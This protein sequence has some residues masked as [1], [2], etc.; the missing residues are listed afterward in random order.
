MPI[1]KP[2]KIIIVGG[3]IGGLSSALALAKIGCDVS[4]LERAKE[5]G[6]IGAG[7]Q[8]GPNGFH[9]LDKLGVG[10]K[11]KET[12]VHVDA[13]NLMDSTDGKIITSIN[14]DSD[15]INHFGNPYRVIHR[16]D[17]LDEL[18]L[19]CK[20]HPK[21]TLLNNCRVASYSNTKKSVIIRTVSGEEFI[22]DA[23]IG[24]DG[25][26]SQIRAQMTG[27]DPLRVP[28][29]VTYRAVVSKFD[30]PAFAQS[31]S[32][33]LW[34]GPK[35]HVVHYPLKG[36]T[37]INLV[38]TFQGEIKDIGETGSIGEKHELMMHFNDSVDSLKQLLNAPVSWKKWIL[39]D[40]EPISAWTDGRVTLLGDAA[41][42]TLQYMAQGA[43]MAL[44]DSVCIASMLENS[45]GDVRAAFARYEVE[46]MPRSYRVVLQ[47]RILGDIYHA[48]GPYR[49]VRNT[50]FSGKSNNDHL[51]SLKWL[52]NFKVA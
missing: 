42:P 15:F 38:A 26:N 45:E 17:L 11:I 1:L 46:R 52:Y 41:H 12:S 18:L 19:A 36:N 49:M 29:H 16:A 32:V 7:I 22:G 40:R 5:F 30:V 4:V 21:I 39:A 51:H 25:L 23:A 2:L 14:L 3:G 13:L 47:S 31:N 20:N 50:M 28:G 9:A 35:C 10:K 34:A 48:Q 27:G 33:T 24:C 8:I 6:E 44:E 37:Q 43:C